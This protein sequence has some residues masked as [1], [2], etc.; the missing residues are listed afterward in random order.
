MCALSKKRILFLAKD[1]PLAYEAAQLLKAHFTSVDV[2]FGGRTD[3]FPRRLLK[4]RY[5]YIISYISPWI[6]PKELLKK[7]RVAAINFHPGS[8]EYPGIGCTN[9]VIYEGAKKYGVTAHHM[10]EKVDTGKIIDVKWFPVSRLDT[11]YSLTMKCYAHIFILFTDI[12]EQMLG[13]KKWGKGRYVWKRK[14]FVRKELNGLCLLTKKM[15]KEE[16]RRRIRATTYPGM[17][18]AR[19]ID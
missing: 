10:N 6:V 14:P 13:Q 8:P 17:P 12:L 7:T 2:V 19:W 18:G 4:N 16:I 9:F 11:V 15:P 1:K 5:D 3:P